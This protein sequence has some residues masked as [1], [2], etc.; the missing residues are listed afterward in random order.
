VSGK[1]MRMSAP[2]PGSNG[3]REW[4]AS[5]STPSCWR[6]LKKFLQEVSDRLHR[7]SAVT[8]A[9]RGTPNE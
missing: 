6:M 2:C 9:Q 4:L 7:H 1:D 8:S 3:I 5:Q